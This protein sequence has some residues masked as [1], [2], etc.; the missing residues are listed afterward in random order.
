MKHRFQATALAAIAATLA[1][2]APAEAGSRGERC[3]PTV[4]EQLTQLQLSPD[5]V[6]GISYQVKRYTS[7]NDTDRVTGIL[8][9]IELQGCN[10]KLVI[11]MSSRCRFKQAYTTDECTVEGLSNW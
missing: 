7:R 2:Q 3:E 1:T 11:D 6:G 5:Q 9:W 8:A 10:G 4:Q